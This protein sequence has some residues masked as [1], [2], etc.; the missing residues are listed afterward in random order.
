MG[1]PADLA[2]P[3]QGAL[4]RAQDQVPGPRALPG[5]SRYEPKWDGFRQVSTSG[6]HGLRLWSKSGTDMTSRFPELAS[7]ATALV[8]SGTVLDGEAL[9]W[10]DGRLRCPEAIPALRCWPAALP[11]AWGAFGLGLV[12]LADYVRRAVLIG[13]QRLV[14]PEETKR[15]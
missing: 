5:G 12:A 9:I 1:L 4:A 13:K 11:F 10:L 2:G 7:A 6:S 14:E 3:V 8:P 15:T